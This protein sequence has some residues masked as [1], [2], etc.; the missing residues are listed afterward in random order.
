[1]KKTKL[2]KLTIL[3]F[4]LLVTL[5]ASVACSGDKS[6]VYSSTPDSNDFTSSIPDSRRF[7]F[8]MMDDD[9]YGIIDYYDDASEIVIP[10]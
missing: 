2:L 9:T 10:S 1:M 5:V 6:P 7:E 8:M 4:T 3:V